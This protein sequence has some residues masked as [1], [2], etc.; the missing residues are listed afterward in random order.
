MVFDDEISVAD[1]TAGSDL[2]DGWED[3]RVGY[4]RYIVATGLVGANA[5]GEEEVSVRVGGKEVDRLRTQSLTLAMPSTSMLGIRVRVPANSLIQAVVLTP[6][7]VSPT[8]LR[9]V[10]VP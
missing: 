5:V 10:C 4:N 3:A 1:S 8:R 2:L 9:L 6:P 7:T